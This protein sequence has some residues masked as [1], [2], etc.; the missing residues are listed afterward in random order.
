MA[1]AHTAATA[2]AE[3]VAMCSGDA[4]PAAWSSRAAYWTAV[5]YGTVALRDAPAWADAQDRWGRLWDVVR[6]EHL[7]PI[8]G[9]PE[10][11]QQ[12]ATATVAEH[13]I[14]Q[15]RTMVGGRKRR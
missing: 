4:A 11:G 15:M 5:R 9:A 3:A 13:N 7:P 14:A 8:P 12:R 6:Q 1:G 10:V 2:F